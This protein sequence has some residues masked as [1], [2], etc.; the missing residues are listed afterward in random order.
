MSN[1]QGAPHGGTDAILDESRGVLSLVGYA[2][3]REHL[4][5]CARCR[6]KIKAWK[7]FAGMT[8]RL[9]EA[10]PPQ[11]VVDRAKALAHR[12]SRVTRRTRLNAALQ[13]DSVW[14]PLA[15]GL[16]GASPDQTVY[17]AEEFAIELRLSRDRT[18]VVIVGQVTN[19]RRPDQRVADVRVDLMCDRRVVMRTVSNDRGEFQL[20]HRERDEMWI[21]VVTKEGRFIRIP[22][23]PKQMAS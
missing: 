16:R 12:P 17:R 14:V 15:A 8:G 13:Y 2:Q 1:R 19:V 21:E 7:N 23:R 5:S 10:E 6:D 3:M 9:R 18:N 22:L 11:E 4:V 20:E